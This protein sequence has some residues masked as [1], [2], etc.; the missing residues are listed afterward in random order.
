MARQS[1][2]FGAHPGFEIG[3]DGNA[4]LLARCLAGDGVEAVDRALD[5]EQD[6]NLSRA[7]P[8]AAS[9]I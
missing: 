8:K 1:C 3:D 4:L 2:A 5:I 6:V 9:K 7:I